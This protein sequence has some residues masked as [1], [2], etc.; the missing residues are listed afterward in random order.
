MELL[1]L[2]YF[3]TVARLEHMTRAAKELSIAQPSLSQ[4]IKRL[5]NEIGVPLFDRKGRRIKLNSYG[6]LFLKKVETA[7]SILQEGK[8]EVSDLA[9]V[10]NDRIALAVMRTPIVPDLLSSFRKKHPYVRF[11]VKQI[12]RDT[13]NRQL[14]NGDI[15][16]CITPYYRERESR[17]SWREL[18]NDEIYLAVPKSHPLASEE[19]VSLRE[20][21]HEP[22]ILKSG[23]AFRETTD[24]Y[25]RMAGFQPDIAFEV[26]DS[27]SIRGLVREGLG[28][29]FFSSLTLR[30]IRDSSI[31]PLRISQP[32]CF[33]TISLVWNEDRYHS[34]IAAQFRQFVIH[35][36]AALNHS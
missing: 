25:C 28:V 21:A 2:K 16:I 34:P 14:E 3:Q 4:T 31:V 22:F 32:H 17:F 9:Q 15:D 13:V 35:Y 11:R 7:L 5:E 12:S 29:A 18:M 1:Q 24:A 19:S 8:R 30:T 27:L 6:K 23:G 36:F 33:R 10:K 26:D 20:I